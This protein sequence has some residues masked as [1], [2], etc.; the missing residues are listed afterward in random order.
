[1]KDISE[2]NAH[3]S[4]RVAVDDGDCSPVLPVI[5]SLAPNR[6]CDSELTML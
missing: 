4:H 6:E 1:M 3:K 5:Q 2:P